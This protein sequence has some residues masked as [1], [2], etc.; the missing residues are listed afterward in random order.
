MCVL[1]TRYTFPATT[2]A[3]SG[4]CFSFLEKKDLCE[5]VCQESQECQLAD[6]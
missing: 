3:D 6:L 4:G 1:G 2:G 5:S